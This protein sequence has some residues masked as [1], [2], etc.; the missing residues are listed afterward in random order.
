M[1]RQMFC[2]FCKNEGEVMD[3]NSF[4]KPKGWGTITVNVSIPGRYGSVQEGKDI[5]N[6][7]IDKKFPDKEET[8]DRRQ[9][10]LDYL[11][12]Y[13]NEAVGEAMLNA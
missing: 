12:D 2:D 6:E 3:L 1:S 9:T 10:L 7:C 5:C 13:I 8:T 11:D 4:S